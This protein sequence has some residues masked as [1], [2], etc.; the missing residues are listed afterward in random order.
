VTAIS[1]RAYT[2]GLLSFKHYHEVQEYRKGEPR[3]KMS[4]FIEFPVSQFSNPTI[5]RMIYATPCSVLKG[6]TRRFLFSTPITDRRT[7]KKKEMRPFFLQAIVLCR[8]SVLA[9]R[10]V[11]YIGPLTRTAPLTS[12]VAFYIFIQQI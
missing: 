12:K 11:S 10:R 3:H 4:L 9:F 7:R 2:N 6:T 8:N 5:P 1:F